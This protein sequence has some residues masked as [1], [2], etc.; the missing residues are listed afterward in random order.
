M[1]EY[2]FNAFISIITHMFSFLVNYEFESR[3]SFDQIEFNENTIKE[4]VNQFKSRKI[5][6]IMKSIWKFVKEHMKKNQNNQVKYAN[7]HRIIASNYQIKNRIWLFNKN[8]QIDRSLRKLNHK[9]LKSFRILK[10]RE[11]SYKFDFSNDMNLHSIFHTSLLKKNFE[12]FLSKQIIFSSSSVV[13]N[14]EQKFDVENIIDSRLTKR[15]INKKLQYKIKWMKHSSNRKWYS[16]ENFE[17]AK[18]IVADYH[19]KYLDKSKSH[20]LIIQ[21]LFISLIT[22]FINSFSWVQKNIQK[23]KT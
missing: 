7:K 4:R 5:M 15:S 12:D 21:S 6:F 11:N 23:T 16:I 1:T 10:K 20:F 17:N 14:D 3:M 22:H 8:I 9:M 18:K 19:Q 2:A 13:I